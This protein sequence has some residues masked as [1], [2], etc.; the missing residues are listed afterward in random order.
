[1]VIRATLEKEVNGDMY[2]AREVSLGEV[3]TGKA[4]FLSSGPSK[5]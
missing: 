2:D 3:T 1:M 4:E 5:I